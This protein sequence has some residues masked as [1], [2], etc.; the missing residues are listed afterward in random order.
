VIGVSA[1]HAT[2]L[3]AALLAGRPVAV[4]EEPTLAG[5]LAGGIGAGNRHSLR[6]VHAL[7]DE[8]LVVGESEIAAAMRWAK[9]ELGLVVEGGGAV[10]LAALLGGGASVA[11]RRWGPRL[12]IVLSGGNVDPAVLARVAHA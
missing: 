11:S 7:L 10:A 3:H 9:T 1:S 4:T 2:A 8:G 12:G 6:I 5:A